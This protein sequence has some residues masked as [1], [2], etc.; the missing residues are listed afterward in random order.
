MRAACAVHVPAAKNLIS[1][2]SA[3]VAVAC[4]H[5]CGVGAWTVRSRIGGGSVRE[6][7]ALLARFVCPSVCLF[8]WNGLESGLLLARLV[9]C[10]LVL[11]LL[12]LLLI[13]A[14]V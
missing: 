12:V 5:R 11:F 14:F 7:Y 4:P 2:A 10:I 9:L 13:E 6:R 1:C 8:A 3:F